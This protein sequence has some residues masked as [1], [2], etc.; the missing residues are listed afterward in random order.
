MSY[1]ATIRT[2]FAQIVLDAINAAATPGI[3]ELGTTSFSTILAQIPLGDPAGT[4]SNVGGNIVLT[5][6]NLPK[7]DSSANN[8]GRIREARIT[9]GDG[10]LVRSGLTVGLLGAAATAW[11]GSTVY[12]IGAKRSN[13]GN[14]YRVLTAGT[15]ASSGGPTGTGSSITDGTVVWEYLAPQYG[16][17]IVNEVDIEAGQQATVN[18]FTQTW[19]A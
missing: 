6:A 19:P 8:S 1:S 16:Q 11:A 3:L 17:I 2:A 9:D 10:L 14:I 13:G 12:A 18:S 7:S 15:S 5:Y 4:I